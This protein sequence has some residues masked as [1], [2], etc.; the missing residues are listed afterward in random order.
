MASIKDIA[1][2]CGV[3]VAT[4]SKALNDKDDISEKT[5]EEI[6]RVAREMSYFPQFY[7]RAIRMNKSYNLGVLFVD[8][9]MSGLTHDYFANILNSFK[10]TAEAKGYDIT[11]IN[12]NKR[13]VNNKTYLEHC[14]YRGLDGVVIACIDFYN[15][16]VVALINS[17]I[18]TVTI[19]KEFEGRTSI[20]SDNDTGMRELIE[21]IIENGHENIAYIHGELSDVTKHRINI[22]KE[23]MKEHGIKTSSNRI[24]QSEYR[25][26][27]KAGEITHKLLKQKYPPTCIVYSDDYSAIGGIGAINDMGLSIPGDISIAG[28]DDIFLA[29]QLVPR[30]TTVKQYTEN[31]GTIAAEKLIALIESGGK[32]EHETITVPTSLIKGETVAN[33]SK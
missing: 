22:F 3:S 5:K 24:L 32:A 9:S 7:A 31:I 15:P 13:E 26:P 29:G 8:E 12:S 18:P 19:D 23:V 1:E 10:V 30:L 17:S 28:F 4:V 6:K 20:N 25:N 21:Y 11:F 2:M 16:E 27:I 14:R 33:V